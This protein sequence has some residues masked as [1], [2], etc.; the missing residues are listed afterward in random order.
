MR[1]RERL[2]AASELDDWARAEAAPSEEEIAR[3]RS[4]IRR[5]ET[6]LNALTPEDR[7]EIRQATAVLRKSR[8]AQLGMPAVRPTAN[9]IRLGREA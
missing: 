1:N 2:T 4:L 8:T 3:L 9:G 5:V 7:E 6:D